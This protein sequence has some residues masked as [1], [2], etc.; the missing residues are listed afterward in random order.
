MV[1][2]RTLPMIDRDHFL[3]AARNGNIK[4]VRQYLLQPDADLECRGHLNMTAL[5]LASSE[6]HREIVAL[7]VERGTKRRSMSDRLKIE[8]FS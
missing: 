2:E 6:G 4:S 5:L 7:L 8:Y 3:T 1:I